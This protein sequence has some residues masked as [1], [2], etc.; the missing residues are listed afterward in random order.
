MVTEMVTEEVTD[1]EPSPKK[2]I[3]TIKPPNTLNFAGSNGNSN[4]DKSKN[5]PS[6]KKPNTGSTTQT[7]KGISSFFSKKA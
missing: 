1:D 2:S 7:Q 4:L 5:V 3:S 6:S